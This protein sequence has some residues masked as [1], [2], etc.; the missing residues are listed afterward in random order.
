MSKIM[1]PST[2]HNLPFCPFQKKLRINMIQTIQVHISFQWYQNY[3]FQSI[4]LFTQY[5]QIPIHQ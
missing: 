5:I 2:K 3:F 4:I 1:S